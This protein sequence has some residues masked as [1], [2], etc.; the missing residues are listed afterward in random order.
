MTLLFSRLG[1]GA[2]TYTRCLP[3]D[4]GNSD[5][6]RR[7]DCPTLTP[8]ITTPNF[9]T[10]PKVPLRSSLIFAGGKSV[11]TRRLCHDQYLEFLR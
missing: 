3:G 11:S 5:G 4:T 10:N 8:S 7:A 1:R 9:A 2:L 6:M